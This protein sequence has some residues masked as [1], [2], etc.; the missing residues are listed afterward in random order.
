MLQ[1]ALLA[2]GVALER[3]VFLPHRIAATTLSEH[4]PRYR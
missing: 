3:P 4:A 2:G 1:A